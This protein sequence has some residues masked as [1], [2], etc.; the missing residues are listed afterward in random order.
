M[1][2]RQA[3]T[4]P[5]LSYRNEVAAEEAR[6]IEMRRN[7]VPVAEEAVVMDETVMEKTVVEEG[8]KSEE[9]IVIQE[10]PTQQA[11]VETQ[12]LV[13]VFDDNDDVVDVLTHT[14]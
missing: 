11:E 4:K 13:V 14:T 5:V 10:T 3:T 7:E 8:L 6:E 12:E 2:G 9:V 1:D